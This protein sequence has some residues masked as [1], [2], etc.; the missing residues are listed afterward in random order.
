V[1]LAV[2]AASWG[3]VAPQP[4]AAGATAGSVQK[5]G[6]TLV[7]TAYPGFG[8]GVTL[9]PGGVADLEIVDTAGALDLLDGTCAPSP[10]LLLPTKVTCDLAGITLVKL[11]GG[12]GDDIMAVRDP[13]AALM[14]GG[15][16]ND[17]LSGGAGDDQLDGGSG[18]DV[19]FGGAGNDVLIGGPGADQLDGGLGSDLADYSLSSIGITADADGQLRDDGTP[20]EG[21]SIGAD[22]ERLSGGAGPDVLGGNGLPNVLQGNGGPDRLAGGAG[23][24]TLLGGAGFDHLD[25]GTGP[26]GTAEQDKCG[27]GADGATLLHCE[28]VIR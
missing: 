21:D 28:V 7:V 23:P 2:L 18:D 1:L 11:D 14:L 15:A 9:L 24:D 26:T 6:S 22:V 13:M 10:T 4:A 27:P 16:G 25:G 12:D 8:N 19:L 20:G 3:V 5:V 17:D